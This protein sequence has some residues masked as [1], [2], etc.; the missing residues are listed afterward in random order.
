MKKINLYFDKIGL[1]K[2]SMLFAQYNRVLNMFAKTNLLRTSVFFIFILC[3]ISINSFGQGTNCATADPFCT[4]TSYV[5][6]MNT[7]TIAEDGPD[8]GCLCEQPNPVWYYL[9]IDNPGNI[10]IGISSPTGNDVDF[11]AWGP[12]SSPTAPC[13]AQ[14][15]AAQVVHLV[16]TTLILFRLIQAVIQW[17]AVLTRQPVKFFIYQML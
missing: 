13:T 14:L 5:F 1:K 4:G 10:T 16:I 17:I 12:F 3:V 9:L 11:T 7:E 6:P 8:Y 2:K 15:T